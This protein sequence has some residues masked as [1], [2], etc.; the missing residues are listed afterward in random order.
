[1]TP[2]HYG[3]LLPRMAPMWAPVLEGMKDLPFYQDPVNRVWLE[4]GQINVNV[5][6]PGPAT[7]WAGEVLSSQ[8]LL[9]AL[10]TAIVD[11]VPP[12]EALQN[13]KREIEA[14]MAK[15]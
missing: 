3:Q 6:Y 7:P 13:A 9:R 11:G 4:A 10:Q 5:G 15:Y 12:A 2:E 1:M 14:I 8:V